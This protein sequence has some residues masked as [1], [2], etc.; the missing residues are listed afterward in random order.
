MSIL[1]EIIPPFLYRHLAPIYKRLNKSNFLYWE[2]NYSSWAEA[3]SACKGY[4]ASAVLDK[5][6]AAALKVKNGD[7][8]FERDSVLFHDHEYSWELLACILKVAGEWNGRLSVLDFGGSLGSTWF[9]NKKMLENLN[10]VTWCIV[11]QKKFVDEGQSLFQDRVLKFEYSIDEAV[12]KYDPNLLILGS[13]LQYL[14]D[15]YEWLQKFID[16][17]ILYIIIERTPF[18]KGEKDRLTIQ[19]VPEKIYD[20]S[21]P[22]WFLSEQKFLEM[23]LKKYQLVASYPLKD[24]TNIPAESKGFFLKLK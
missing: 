10:S 12:A 23:M 4:D 2:G 24:K 20:G 18:I 11:E 9:Q 16:K 21:Y 15:P 6:K 3:S 1:S 5:V 8:A 17:R 22:S 13:V 14:P 19:H 7:A